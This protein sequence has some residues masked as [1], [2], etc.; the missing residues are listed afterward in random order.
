MGKQLSCE[1][2]SNYV[3]DEEEEEYFCSQSMDEDDFYRVYAGGFQNCPY[4]SLDD[5]YKIV[6]SQM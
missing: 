5:E 2:C 3:Y 1:T 4:Y 6:R